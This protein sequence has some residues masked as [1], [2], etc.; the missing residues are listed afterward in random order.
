VAGASLFRAVLYIIFAEVQ[1]LAGAILAKW[2]TVFREGQ[3]GM[4]V[5]IYICSM[6]CQPH[7]LE[8]HGVSPIHWSVAPVDG[9]D[10]T[11]LQ[12]MGLTP[13]G[14]SGWG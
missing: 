8:P 10:T 9:A 12:W 5:C 4:Y 2:M 11:W 1:T 7:P 6:W 14:S 13:C 3:S